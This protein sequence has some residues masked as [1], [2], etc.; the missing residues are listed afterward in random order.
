MIEINHIL[1]P[2]DFSDCSEYA[3]KYSITLAKDFDA[4]ITLVS[5]SEHVPD[6]LTFQLESD[7]GLINQLEKLVDSIDW[8]GIAVPKVLVRDG[9]PFVEII[10]CARE[11]EADLIVV[12]AHGRSAKLK[13]VLIGS[14][15]ERVV[16]KAHCPVLTVH[17]PEYIPKDIEPLQKILFPADFSKSSKSA[18]KYCAFFAK[19]YQSKVHMLHALHDPA[20]VLAGRLKHAVRHEAEREMELYLTNPIW[21]EIPIDVEFKEGPPHAEIIEAAKKQRANLIVMSTHGHGP[22]QH[23][24]I[25]AVTERVVRLAPCSVLTIHPESEKTF[26]LP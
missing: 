14:N 24:L 7:V 10:K 9:T 1:C 15:T 5:V 17:R 23:L 22:I 6:Y 20:V 11:I 18:A 26:E 21:G 25:G 16:R 12:G 4:K 3:L 13:D 8:C 19:K 2:I